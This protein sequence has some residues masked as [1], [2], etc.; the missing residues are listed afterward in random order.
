[1]ITDEQF[2]DYIDKLSDSYESIKDLVYAK[3]SPLNPLGKTAQGIIEELSNFRN[4]ACTALREAH[5][6]KNFNDN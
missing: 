5:T 4:I 6:T 3:G 1:M 2:K